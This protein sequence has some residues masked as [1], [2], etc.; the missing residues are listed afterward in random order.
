MLAAVIE[1]SEPKRQGATLGRL[2]ERKDDRSGSG[3]DG[4]AVG[5]LDVPVALGVFPCAVAAFFV[6]VVFAAQWSAVVGGRV[7]GVAPW[8]D[9]IGLALVGWNMAS[10]PHAGR[11]QCL[12][13][14][15]QRPSER[16]RFL[17]NGCLRYAYDDASDMARHCCTKCFTGAERGA[18]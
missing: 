18:T 17:R 6:A 16:S 2:R 15:A 13:E 4:G 8:C 1:R 11:V 12:D 14:R 10:G 3:C 9:V 7:L 5:A